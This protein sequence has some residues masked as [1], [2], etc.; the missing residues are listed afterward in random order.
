MD[1]SQLDWECWNAE[2]AQRYREW[3]STSSSLQFL[4][5]LDLWSYFSLKCPLRGIPRFPCSPFSLDPSGTPGPHPG[6]LNFTFPHSCSSSWKKRRRRCH[7]GCGKEEGRGNPKQSLSGVLPFS[8]SNSFL[9]QNT[10]VAGKE[11]DEHTKGKKGAQ[12]LNE[13]TDLRHAACISCLPCSSESTLPSSVSFSNLVLPFST[14]TSTC[15]SGATPSIRTS[16]EKNMKNNIYSDSEEELSCSCRGEDEE[17]PMESGR[18][19]YHQHRKDENSEADC[20]EDSEHAILQ[21]TFSLP[22]VNVICSIIPAS[23]LHKGEGGKAKPTNTS[24]MHRFFTTPRMNT[25]STASNPPTVTSAS[26]ETSPVSVTNAVLQACL[27]TCVKELQEA[28]KGSL[29]S[30]N[31]SSL[32]S[33]LIPQSF[34]ATA[35]SSSLFADPSDGNTRWST[36]PASPG[37]APPSSATAV[38]TVWDHRTA[39]PA[40]RSLPS[41]AAPPL[42]EPGHLHQRSATATVT[43]LPSSSHTLELKKM[44]TRDP[45]SFPRP[46]L[47]RVPSLASLSEK[48]SSSSDAPPRRKGGEVV[49]I[50]GT[51]EPFSLLEEKS[52]TTMKSNE[53]GDGSPSPPPPS[54]S[55]MG[56]VSAPYATPHRRSS[57]SCSAAGGG[58]FSCTGLSRQ[59]A[60]PP[61]SPKGT[62]EGGNKK[63]RV[64]KPLSHEERK[65]LPPTSCNAPPWLER[66]GAVTP[67]TTS[68]TSLSPFLAPP[69]SRS[70]GVLSSPDCRTYWNESPTEE[71]WEKRVRRGHA[72]SSPP[73][74]GAT[75]DP[76]IAI[77]VDAQWPCGVGRGRSGLPSVSVVPSSTEG[78]RPIRG[79]RLAPGPSLQVEGPDLKQGSSEVRAVE[80]P[81]APPHGVDTRRR[82]S[83]S[84]A[85]PPTTT[86][87]PGIRRA[88]SFVKSSSTSSFPLNTPDTAHPVVSMTS[89]K[90]PA[91][92]PS[93][94]SSTSHP[95][96]SASSG[97]PFSLVSPISTPF[98]HVLI[99]YVDEALPESTKGELLSSIP[100][101]MTTPN[102]AS[103]RTGTT[104]GAPG[105]T[106]LNPPSLSPARQQP[107]T[108]EKKPMPPS[109]PKGGREGATSP[110]SGSPYFIV[111][112]L[113]SGGGAR[114]GGG[115]PTTTTS[116]TKEASSPFSFSGTKTMGSNIAS[117]RHPTSRHYTAQAYLASAPPLVQFIYDWERQVEQRYYAMV[118]S[119]MPSRIETASASTTAAND[120]DATLPARTGSSSPLLSLPQHHAVNTPT[121][122]QAGGSGKDG[123]HRTEAGDDKGSALPFASFSPQRGAAVAGK[124]KEEEEREE[125]RSEEAQK[126]Y[127]TLYL[128]YH[129][130]LVAFQRETQ[131]ALEREEEVEAHGTVQE[132]RMA[133]SSS[134]ATKK[135]SRDTLDRIE[136][137]DTVEGNWLSTSCSSSVGPLP[138]GVG[139]KDRSPSPQPTLPDT[140]CSLLNVSTSERHIDALKKPQ[141]APL[142]TTTRVDP[143]PPLRKEERT[144]GGAGSIFHN[145]SE[146]V[147]STIG[148][149][150]SAPPPPSTTTP[151]LAPPNGTARE[152]C[153]K[154]SSQ[155]LPSSSSPPVHSMPLVESVMQVQAYAEVLQNVTAVSSLFPYRTPSVGTYTPQ[156]AVLLISNA[157]QKVATSR[158]KALVERWDLY[159]HQRVLL[160]RRG[161]TVEGKGPLPKRVQERIEQQWKAAAHP[162][163]GRRRR[164]CLLEEESKAQ[165]E[166]QEKDCSSKHQRSRRAENDGPSEGV[167]LDEEEEAIAMRAARVA[168]SPHYHWSL[169]HFWRLGYDVILFTLQF[170]HLPIALLWLEHLF[171][172]YYNHSD[173][174]VLVHYG[175][176][177]HSSIWSW[178]S[179]RGVHET[180]KDPQKTS[181]VVA[182]LAPQ[183]G[184]RGWNP[185]PMDAAQG[186]TCLSS[187]SSSDSDRRVPEGKDCACGHLFSLPTSLPLLLQLSQLRGLLDPRLYHFTRLFPMR[188]DQRKP[189][190]GTSLEVAVGGHR[191][192]MHRDRNLFHYG[193]SLE[194]V[195]R[196]SEEETIIHTSY[197]HMRRHSYSS[198]PI[199]TSTRS[200]RCSRREEEE[201]VEEVA[202]LAL[203]FRYAFERRG[204]EEHQ[205]HKPSRRQLLPLSLVA[206]S[207]SCMSTTVTPLS[208]LSFLSHSN[209]TTMA[210]GSP[211]PLALSPGADPLLGVLFLASMEVVC[212]KLLQRREEKEWGEWYRY[213][214]SHAQHSS[215]CSSAENDAFFAP[216]AG[217]AEAAGGQRRPLQ[218]REKESNTVVREDVGTCY[219]PPFEKGINTAD[220][221]PVDP[222]RRTCSLSLSPTLL[223]SPQRKEEEA[224]PLEIPSSLLVR[225]EET[226]KLDRS[227]AQR[228]EEILLEEKKRRIDVVG[229]KM[230]DR[231]HTLLGCITEILKEN[232]SIGG[233]RTSTS[234]PS[235]RTLRKKGPPYSEEGKGKR[236]EEDIKNTEDSQGR[237]GNGISKQSTRRGST[238]GKEEN[239]SQEGLPYSLWNPHT[240]EGR[241]FQHHLFLLQLYCSGLRVLWPQVTAEV[242]QEMAARTPEETLDFPPCRTTHTVGKETAVKHEW[243]EAW[244]HS[245]PRL[246]SSSSPLQELKRKKRP[247]PTGV[248]E[249]FAGWIYH[250]PSPCP[251]FPPLQW[252]SSSSLMTISTPFPADGKMASPPI[253]RKVYFMTPPLMSL[254]GSSRSF[255][256]SF[257]ASDGML[258][259]SFTSWKWLMQQAM[260]WELMQH[261]FPRH[262]PCRR[263]GRHPPPPLPSPFTH[264][265]HEKRKRNTTQHTEHEGSSF[266]VNPQSVCL[267]FAIQDVKETRRNFSQKKEKVCRKEETHKEET[268]GQAWLDISSEPRRCCSSSASSSSM[269]STSSASSF[270]DDPIASSHHPTKDRKTD[271]CCKHCGRPIS[272]NSSPQETRRA[273]GTVSI[274][275]DSEEE[276]ERWE[277]SR[278]PSLKELERL[279]QL[280]V[281]ARKSL[282][283]L[284]QSLAW[285]KD[286][287]SVP[288]KFKQVPL[289]TGERGRRTEK[290]RRSVSLLEGV[291][292]VSHLGTGLEESG[293][294]E[295]VEHVEEDHT[296]EEMEEGRRE[297]EFDALGFP[298]SFV[299]FPGRSTDTSCSMWCVEKWRGTNSV[300]KGW[301]E[302]CEMENVASLWLGFTV[303]AAELLLLSE[304]PRQAFILY[305]RVTLLLLLLVR[306]RKKR[307]ATISSRRTEVDA[308]MEAEHATYANGIPT[309]LVCARL[310][311]HVVYQRLLPL[312]RLSFSF[313]SRTFP[314]LFSPPPSATRRSRTM[315]N[316]EGESPRVAA[317]TAGP[318]S[319]VMS[320]TDH[321]W[322]MVASWAMKL[323]LEC[324]VGL[325][326]CFPFVSPPALCSSKAP[327]HSMNGM[328]QEPLPSTHYSRV[329]RRKTSLLHA[330]VQERTTTY[331]RIFFPFVRDGWSGDA[332]FEF[333]FG[334]STPETQTQEWSAAHDM[335]PSTSSWWTGWSSVLYPTA[336]VLHSPCP[337]S[338]G[339]SLT[340][341]MSTNA[342]PATTTTAG[343]SNAALRKRVFPRRVPSETT[344]TTTASWELY[345][346]CRE[347]VM[348]W[349]QEPSS[350][351]SSSLFPSAG[352][353]KKSASKGKEKGLP[354]KEVMVV[355]MK[356]DETS[357][358]KEKP[359]YPFPSHQKTPLKA[360]GEKKPEGPPSSFL[361]S[362]LF[363]AS[364]RALADHWEKEKEGKEC[365][366]P[367]WKVEDHPGWLPLWKDHSSPFSMTP[368]RRGVQL[369][370]TIDEAATAAVARIRTCLSSQPRRRGNKDRATATLP[371]FPL[372]LRT[373]SIPEKHG[374]LSSSIRPPHEDAS[375]TEK[376]IPEDTVKDGISTRFSSPFTGVGLTLPLPVMPLSLVWECVDVRVHKVLP[377]PPPSPPAF[378]SMFPPLPSS[379]R[380]RRTSSVS[381]PV[382]EKTYPTTR[383][384]VRAAEKEEELQEEGLPVLYSHYG[385]AKDGQG[386]TTFPA[387]NAAPASHRSSFQ[388][389]EDVF[390]LTLKATCLTELWEVEE[391]FHRSSVSSSVAGTAVEPLTEER[392]S[393]IEVQLTLGIQEGEEE[394]REVVNPSS[395][396]ISPSRPEIKKEKHQKSTKKS[397]VVLF[398]SAYPLG[399]ASLLWDSSTCWSIASTGTMTPMMGSP[400]DAPIVAFPPPRSVASSASSPLSGSLDE[401]PWTSAS[402]FSYDPTTRIVRISFTLPGTSAG[403]DG[404]SAHRYCNERE[405]VEMTADCYQ[406]ERAVDASI[407]TNGSVADPVKPFSL[408]PGRYYVQAMRVARHTTVGVEVRVPTAVEDEPSPLNG[409]PRDGG[410]PFPTTALPS[411]AHDVEEAKDKTWPS[412]AAPVVA[413][414][415]FAYVSS[416]PPLVPP[417]RT[418][419]C[420]SSSYFFRPRWL[421]E[422]K[423]LPPPLWL[424]HQPTMTIFIRH[425][426]L[427]YD[428]HTASPTGAASLLMQTG[429]Q[430]REGQHELS[431]KRVLVGAP[432]ASL[433][434]SSPSLTRW[435]RPIF[436]AWMP[437]LPRA[438]LEH[439][440]SLFPFSSPFSNEVSSLF[441]PCF[442]V[443]LECAV[444]SPPTALN[445]SGGGGFHSLLTSFLLSSYCDPFSLSLSSPTLASPPMMARREGER[446]SPHVPAP[447][448]EEASHGIPHHS[449]SPTP[450]LQS[451]STVASRDADTEGK[452]T[453]EKKT[454]KKTQQKGKLRWPKSLHAAVLEMLHQAATS[455]SSTCEENGVQEDTRWSAAGK[456]GQ[457]WEKTSITKRDTNTTSEEME[458]P[459]TQESFFPA[460][461]SPVTSPLCFPYDTIAVVSVAARRL[462]VCLPRTV[463]RRMT[464]N[465]AHLVPQLEHHRNS[466]EGTV[467]EPTPLTGRTRTRRAGQKGKEERRE[468]PPLMEPS[469]RHEQKTSR[470]EDDL[471]ASPA[472][473]VEDPFGTS[474][475][476]SITAYR[477]M[478]WMQEVWLPAIAPAVQRSARHGGAP[479]LL[480]V[481]RHTIP[482]ESDP[483][484]KKTKRKQ[485]KLTKTSEDPFLAEPSSVLHAFPWPLMEEDEDEEES[486]SEDVASSSSSCGEHPVLVVPAEDDVVRVGPSCPLPSP[487][488]VPNGRE[489]STPPG[490]NRFHATR[491]AVVEF[492]IIAHDPTPSPSTVSLPPF[493][494]GLGMR[495][496]ST[497]FPAF[498]S[499]SPDMSGVSSGARVP[500]SGDSTP[501]TPISPS[502]SPFPSPLASSPS[503]PTPAT[504]SAP[505]SATPSE[506][507]HRRTTVA[508]SSFPSPLPVG[509]TT[510][511]AVPS[512]EEELPVPTASK[513]KVSSVAPFPENSLSRLSLEKKAGMDVMGSLFPS[514][515]I[516]PYTRPGPTADDF[517]GSFLSSPSL[518]DFL[519]SALSA[520]TTSLSSPLSATKRGDVATPIPGVQAISKE[521]EEE[522][523]GDKIVP[524]GTVHHRHHTETV[525]LLR[526]RPSPPKRNVDPCEKDLSNLPSSYSTEKMATM[527]TKMVK[528]RRIRLPIEPLWM[529][530]GIPSRVGNTSGTR[531]RYTHHRT[532]LSSTGRVESTK[533]DSP[534]S[535][536]SS[537]ATQSGW[538]AIPRSLQRTYRG[539]RQTHCRSLYSLS[540]SCASTPSRSSSVANHP[541]SEKPFRPKGVETP[542]Q[543]KTERKRQKK[544]KPHRIH[545]RQAPRNGACQTIASVACHAA[546][547]CGVPRRHVTYKPHRLLLTLCAGRWKKN[548][549][550]N[551]EKEDR[552]ETREEFTSV[553]SLMSS[554][555]FW[556]RP[557]CVLRLPPLS[558][559]VEK[560]TS[561]AVQ[562]LA[563]C[564]IRS[565]FP[566][567]FGAAP[568]VIRSMKLVVHPTEQ[569]ASMHLMKCSSLSSS[570]RVPCHASLGQATP[571]MKHH[572]DQEDQENGVEET[573]MDAIAKP[574][575]PHH[576]ETWRQSGAVPRKKYF[577]IVEL[578]NNGENRDI[579]EKST[580][581]ERSEAGTQNSA[582][583]KA[584]K[585]KDALRYTSGDNS[586]SSH[587]KNLLLDGMR[588]LKEMEEEGSEV[589]P[590]SSNA[591]ESTSGD[592]MDEDDES[593]ECQEEEE[594]EEP[595]LWLR[596]VVPYVMAHS[597]SSTI[598]QKAPPN[599]SGLASGTEVEWMEKT[600]TCAKRMAHERENLFSVNGTMEHNIKE[601]P[602]REVGHEDGEPAEIHTCSSS[603]FFVSRISSV[604]P[605]LLNLP[606]RR[607]ECRRLMMELIDTWEDHEW[608]DNHIG[609]ENEESK[610]H[611]IRTAPQEAKENEP[612]LASPSS[613]LPSSTPLFVVPS[614]PVS[615]LWYSIRLQLFYSYSIRSEESETPSILQRNRHGPQS[616]QDEEEE[617]DVESFSSPLQRE[618]DIMVNH[619]MAVEE[620]SGEEIPEKAMSRSHKI[621]HSIKEDDTNGAP[622]SLFASSLPFNT[623]SSLKRRW[624]PAVSEV[625]L[626]QYIQEGG[627]FGLPSESNPSPADV[628]ASKEME[629][630]NRGIQGKA[631]ALGVPSCASCRSPTRSSSRAERLFYSPRVWKCLSHTCPS[632]IT[633]PFFFSALP[634]LRGHYSSNLSPL[635]ASVTGAKG[636]TPPIV[637]FSALS[638]DSVSVIPPHS[639][640]IAGEFFFTIGYNVASPSS[641]TPS[642]SASPLAASLL[643][644]LSVSTA[645]P[646]SP[647]LPILP[648]LTLRSVPTTTT[649]PPTVVSPSSP[650]YP[651]I[652]SGKPWGKSSREA[653]RRM[654]AGTSTLCS[655]L[656]TC[657]SSSL[658]RGE[659]NGG[660]SLHMQHTTEITPQPSSLFDAA[661]FP[662]SVSSFG[663]PDSSAPYRSSPSTNMVFSS[664]SSFPFFVPSHV[665]LCLEVRLSWRMSLNEKAFFA[666]AASGTPLAFGLPSSAA[667]APDRS[668]RFTS[669]ATVVVA[670]DPHSLG[671]V[672]MER[673]TMGMHV[674]GEGGGAE[675][676]VT[677]W[678][679]LGPSHVR[680]AF[681]FSSS[682]T[683]GVLRKDDE[684]P[685]LEEVERR[686]E[687]QVGTGVLPWERNT[688]VK[689]SFLLLPLLL[690]A[691]SLMEGAHAFSSS[692]SSHSAFASSC[693]AT[694]KTSSVLRSPLFPSTSDVSSHVVTAT[695]T[696]GAAPVQDATSLAVLSS[697]STSS[698]PAP[699]IGAGPFFVSPAKPDV[700]RCSSPLPPPHRSVVSSQ[701]SYRTSPVS[702]SSPIPVVVRPPPAPS[703]CGAEDVQWFSA[704]SAT[705]TCPK[706]FPIE[707]PSESSTGQHHLH[708]TVPQ[709][710]SSTTHKMVDDDHIPFS[711]SSKPLPTTPSTS[712]SSS[713]MASVR[714]G[715]GGGREGKEGNQMRRG[716]ERMQKGFP[717]RLECPKVNVFYVYPLSGTTTAEGAVA[718]PSLC[719]AAEHPDVQKEGGHQN[720]ARIESSCPE[721]ERETKE[722]WIPVRTEV[723]TYP[724][725]VMVH[726]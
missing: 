680:H 343:S 691:A 25:T 216:L 288:P 678:K 332:A 457:E 122:R 466:V 171:K 267:P 29:T 235:G 22:S 184:S 284:Y 268:E 447:F 31:F 66:K 319:V 514:F 241:R 209:R 686:E 608:K 297:K 720:S 489:A 463:Q 212:W 388:E 412:H 664:A 547:D 524:V 37:S 305:A 130:S 260:M 379:S 75:S 336:S 410:P 646:S 725:F 127:S 586:S 207:S 1:S 394:Q 541:F 663:V 317:P 478:D 70:G 509:R 441:M 628:N 39:P 403:E 69:W 382:W 422:V 697:L 15:H 576:E 428:H 362:F 569:I 595:I 484:L 160:Q 16:D 26:S 9:H 460:A 318:C 35:T 650:S 366:C 105:G 48:D 327:A 252:Y 372:S 552:K 633:T 468:V 376:A 579:E 518:R 129:P 433:P 596:G 162:P 400:L 573:K 418:L 65:S 531:K 170:F 710:Q 365:V 420:S 655:P 164:G 108:V 383:E 200:A 323:F 367:I 107:S 464:R 364:Q 292:P 699:N 295:D 331:Q 548:S 560:K 475:V 363:H 454:K 487:L 373:I 651:L 580:K 687:E 201:E 158:A 308:S 324:I 592:A 60:V 256:S 296:E 419:G 346:Q 444:K 104:H 465:N 243:E 543:T 377:T 703:L 206:S 195:A 172:S 291:D 668:L 177:I 326:S 350:T 585:V 602:I 278:R 133:S 126:W 370:C 304:K 461:L 685:H 300:S 714:K 533:D 558:T 272:P 572:S 406:K 80:T 398:H 626:P 675:N 311:L 51:V 455:F 55:R 470:E 581:T 549:V 8:S 282:M 511:A 627:A 242:V 512:P 614:P 173:D 57:T 436:P 631:N 355:V 76:C 136:E 234:L 86:A 153:V 281:N 325:C 396:S 82:H 622:T 527:Q 340:R 236:K 189:K 106:T 604:L 399:A 286:A 142:V 462:D 93:G 662:S 257:S 67:L 658:I 244:T 432:P 698:S 551:M 329:P 500:F 137:E 705:S 672:F 536:C 521:E 477:M 520:T 335:S 118:E 74:L 722:L 228:G 351:S 661:V 712:G 4:V 711:L 439:G 7:G 2:T 623:V 120:E 13:V 294:R 121:P 517:T 263:H 119:G 204:D 544:P 639:S 676:W 99:I 20:M 607:K 599:A 254:S 320:L 202:N 482:T 352:E 211:Y 169:L 40:S 150:S 95:A 217:D 250:Q 375:V 111:K 397:G 208:L 621:T 374:V 523:E 426:V 42:V 695:R 50:V 411:S 659:E 110:M 371:F 456:R 707:E 166:Q 237:E 656:P 701:C 266:F 617:E 726:P 421:F 360:K 38:P 345:Y 567:P 407:R 333:L 275:E 270:M 499:P 337:S 490:K 474:S 694:G 218:E 11:E 359:P 181:A 553:S 429:A 88:G 14:T 395:S 570:S 582:Q 45:L 144:E 290:R 689:V 616:G 574:F 385:S 49:R 488:Q 378:T 654:L 480:R 277:V 414:T 322:K 550:P 197:S 203:P 507:P 186:A 285:Q 590:E 342:E 246:S 34:P 98:L 445:A 178:S 669:Q 615:P 261:P 568:I 61:G 253:Q 84:S 704:V 476:A 239:I 274:L 637:T 132:G 273:R 117:P 612:S 559:C 225:E 44:A 113:S 182:P 591:A 156:G 247:P 427:W 715:R 670:L 191:P 101:P 380:R 652:I 584:T 92:I 219:P 123:L 647:S 192:S 205:D 358:E 138:S 356:E 636:G 600:K 526:F 450:L 597:F 302:V 497:V 264:S 609:N 10:Q 708:P 657:T 556:M 679:L 5:S 723:E 529:S 522:E 532:R 174:Y 630:E 271:G 17:E 43:A 168:L 347:C 587:T 330:I 494:T 525:Y 649:I 594:E 674:G 606:W 196:P 409:A 471:F 240:R 262:R 449:R 54:P 6:S 528:Q 187:S 83:L 501:P 408:P 188:D 12:G 78:K 79:S 491:N 213:F 644:S 180:R 416:S 233:W 230:V 151:S 185:S 313:P 251:R 348:Q 546:G 193:G 665:P 469:P 700:S 625:L 688:E 564:R 109:F 303:M 437:L 349:L 53:R 259:S 135:N 690:P 147:S 513:K 46:S 220:S 611:G 430:E 265:S 36:T 641:Q 485:K 301:S 81:P 357:Q 161:G 575:T 635:C 481:D 506:A 255:Y 391:P 307:E 620:Q 90:H 458:L 152:G 279:S 492:M 434:P 392:P 578:M 598:S 402:T 71:K 116:T 605:S 103:H 157:L 632:L 542:P 361:L 248:F 141:G 440:F 696:T 27:C 140:S 643:P 677:Q 724:S 653:L 495:G 287:C 3:C 472:A 561:G 666:A 496:A 545:G 709:R 660:A 538:L 713:R 389:R 423:P 681:T 393:W 310:A 438:P 97:P 229:E 565:G 588:A 446:G 85:T 221:A 435:Y 479:V 534:A 163:T 176:S 502:H 149:T 405:A 583:E 102:P 94:A 619:T 563:T 368:R 684:A 706:M 298:P 535:V 115:P 33:L 353:R 190:E 314:L 89:S 112:G 179:P 503:L 459:P 415:A 155:R 566:F 425:Q 63:E 222:P 571:T 671:P 58:S 299:F 91:M 530:G 401:G 473:A 56:S 721:N 72:V 47:P 417:R 312:L 505:C 316:H 232:E 306:W 165:E 28:L 210:Y 719:S 139:K 424:S 96:P 175:P 387:P 610:A 603:R 223:H 519:L 131:A 508:F 245:S 18:D 238:S 73:S 717:L 638:T 640:Q 344:R 442:E 167:V 124:E 183:V 145:F 293:A 718:N 381:F 618:T 413:V 716:G 59:S 283:F 562:L 128:L 100:P 269:D 227:A 498:A 404:A 249:L 384:K 386:G 30:S 693:V 148:F 634:P 134:E 231:V 557:S 154:V 146:I 593:E 692:P 354:Q 510:T 334:V 431:S 642:T 341:Q 64:T 493:L 214:L 224:F 452:K 540:S 667:S 194:R 215:W 589:K 159:Q 673:N 19:V 23:Q 448:T 280:V 648:S 629:K 52:R 702:R 601:E 390:E 453:K 24:G 62:R 483:S 339:P 328:P 21:S 315:Q 682:L 555:P 504:F 554:S 198:G 577:V 199:S 77:Q 613:A 226:E 143:T 309:S 321:S 467:E 289:E 443:S 516:I 537:L 624:V 451:D 683:C 87:T 125:K 114:G 645:H 369:L 32:S 515:S 486:T 41:A 68:S 276:W 338:S 539:R 258:L